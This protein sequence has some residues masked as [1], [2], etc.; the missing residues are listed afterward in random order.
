MSKLNEVLVNT[1]KSDMTKRRCLHLDIDHF[2]DNQKSPSELCV[3]SKRLKASLIEHDETIEKPSVI[4]QMSES[5]EELLTDISIS[6]VPGIRGKAARDLFRWGYINMYSLVRDF[7]IKHQMNELSFQ[8]WLKKNFKLN[9]IDASRVIRSIK[10]LLYD[11][12]N[13]VPKHKKYLTKHEPFQSLRKPCRCF[14]TKDFEIVN[15]KSCESN[16]TDFEN[17]NDA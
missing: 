4:V 8:E 12:L 2:N 13:N 16:E 9:S 1:V 5:S 6:E 11:E 7:V 14:H 10:K 3:S 17:K 15:E